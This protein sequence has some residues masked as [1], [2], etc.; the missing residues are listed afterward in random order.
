[1]GIVLWLV[2]F[3]NA[4]IPSHKK[5]RTKKAIGRVQRLVHLRPKG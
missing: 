4:P 1:M 5:H 3:Y 2:A